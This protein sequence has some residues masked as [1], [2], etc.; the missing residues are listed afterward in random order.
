MALRILYFISTFKY[1]EI[2]AR[3]YSRLF[4]K[5]FIYTIVAGVIFL[6]TPIFAQSSQARSSSNTSVFTSKEGNSVKKSSRIKRNGKNFKNSSTKRKGL[7]AKKK[8][9][10]CDC[11]GSPK[12]KRKRRR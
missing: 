10:D 3:Q 11:P 8:G 2:A 1:I 6:S 5:S 7:F 9:S 4:M 12:A